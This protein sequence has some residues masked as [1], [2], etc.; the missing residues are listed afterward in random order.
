MSTRAMPGDGAA[1][2]GPA[3][4]LVLGSGGREHALV[5]SLAREAAERDSSRQ[6]KQESDCR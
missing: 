6:G 2:R 3:R 1:L 5:W 4:L